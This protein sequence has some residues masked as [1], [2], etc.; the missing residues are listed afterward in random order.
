MSSQWIGRM[1]EYHAEIRAEEGRT[2][3]AAS[4]QTLQPRNGAV[5]IVSLDRGVN[6]KGGQI[7]EAAVSHAS[8]FIVDGSH[9]LAT[10]PEISEYLTDQ[11]ARRLL[12]SA[13]GVAGQR[14]IGLETK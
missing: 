9:R 8:R 11:K 4:Q 12:S 3:A 6:T 7:C 1:K 13:I 2:K 10:D 5:Y 14:S